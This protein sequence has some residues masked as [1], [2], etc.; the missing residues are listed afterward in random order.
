[1]SARPITMA[2][3]NIASLVWEATNSSSPSIKVVNSSGCLSSLRLSLRRGVG[4]DKF[5]P[6]GNGPDKK[7]RA[8]QEDNPTQLHLVLE[9][10]GR[11]LFED[12]GPLVARDARQILLFGVRL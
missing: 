1:M 2:T 3:E 4:I 8:N 9:V 5:G 6:Y 10:L 7:G 12:F 11:H